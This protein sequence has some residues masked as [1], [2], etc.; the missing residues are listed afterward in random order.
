M[1]TDRIFEDI[2]KSLFV[3]CDTGSVVM[4]F[5]MTVSEIPTERLTEKNKQYLGFGLKNPRDVGGRRNRI[6]HE[7]MGYG[8]QYSLLANFVRVPNFP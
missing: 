5:K 3:R 2:K 7:G 8:I 1:N 6:T 4:L